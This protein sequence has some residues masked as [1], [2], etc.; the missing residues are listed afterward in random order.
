M[1]LGARFHAARHRRHVD[2]IVHSDRSTA[3]SATLA[4]VTPSG[5]RPG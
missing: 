1:T 2:V 5:N 4:I 3:V